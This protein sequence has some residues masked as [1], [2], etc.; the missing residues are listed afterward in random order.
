MAELALQTRA[1]T[2]CWRFKVRKSPGKTKDR[3][4]KPK[5]NIPWKDLQYNLVLENFSGISQL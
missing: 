5:T 1:W 3:G 2:D 4:Q